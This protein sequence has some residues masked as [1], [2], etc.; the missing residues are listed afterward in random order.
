MGRWKLFS[1]S[2]KS[3]ASSG[4]AA[5]LTSVAS[6]EAARLGE[7]DGLPVAVTLDGH[8]VALR[9]GR[10][11]L[12]SDSNSVYQREIDTLR[13]RVA[14]LKDEL[15]RARSSRPASRSG[16]PRGRDGR[17][18]P[19]DRHGHGRDRRD[20]GRRSDPE[21]LD[22][23]ERLVRENDELRFRN[24]VLLAMCTISECDYRALFQE[25]G[26]EAP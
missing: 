26:L 19:R 11:E 13:R 21:L 17:G 22:A 14:D 20:D 2:S 9:K 8:E 6:G 24:K 10:W 12:L 7:R 5:L 3:A 4:S 16:S 18:E 25:A 23:N 1:S 15:A